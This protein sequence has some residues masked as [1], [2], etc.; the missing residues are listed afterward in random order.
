MV[1]WSLFKEE[2]GVSKGTAMKG[3]FIHPDLQKGQRHS[4]RPCGFFQMKI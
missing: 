3:F 2:L 1:I 4:E